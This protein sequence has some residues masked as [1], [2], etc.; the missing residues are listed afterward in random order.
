MAHPPQTDSF[1]LSVLQVS[2]ADDSEFER[3]KCLCGIPE[4]MGHEDKNG[5]IEIPRLLAQLFF[6]SD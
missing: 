4:C 3:A 2:T 5:F 6:G 1:V